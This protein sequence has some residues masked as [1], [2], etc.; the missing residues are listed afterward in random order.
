MQHSADQRNITILDLMILT[1]CCLAFFSGGLIKGV[2]GMGLPLTSVALMTQVVDLRI[3]VP[4]LVIPILATN[5]FQAIRGGN[6]RLIISQYWSLIVTACVFTFAGVYILMNVDTALIIM[7]LGAVITVYALVN[8]FAFH[9]TV[10]H[11]HKFWLSPVT[12]IAAGLM[13]GMTGVIAIPTIIYFQAL[14]LRKDLFVQALGITFFI[15]GMFLLLALWQRRI[16]NL[17]NLP[18]SALAM[19]PAMVGMYL[20]EKIRRLISEERFRIGVFLLLALAG[21]NLVRK[22]LS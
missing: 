20:G 12:G 8:I 9:V 15:A 16:L 7:I 22:A 11:K 2:V 5:F 10:S 19:L 17:E 1:I 18:I 4:L 6:A 13:G 14:G 3:A 21:L